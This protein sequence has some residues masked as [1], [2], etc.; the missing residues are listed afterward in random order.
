VR[1]DFVKL[2][3]SN[4]T[5]HTYTTPYASL[6]TANPGDDGSTNAEPT[7]A[8]GYQAQPITW[9]NPTVPGSLDTA[10][11]AVNSAAIN[12]GTGSPASGGSTA[13]YST[14][15]LALAYVGIWSHITSRGETN[16]IARTAVAGGGFA[17]NAA[18]ITYTL[19][20]TT[21]IVLGVISA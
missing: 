3:T 18:G 1:T 7:G 20:A 4:A 13:A 10:C 8:G 2:A 5:A 16:F 21:G 9:T 14:A 19:P 12:F 11:N 15:A 17:V 6:S